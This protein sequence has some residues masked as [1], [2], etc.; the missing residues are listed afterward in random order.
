MGICINI[1]KYEF[2]NG[3]Y[4]YRVVTVDGG[5]HDFFV[6]LSPNEKTIS[7]Y[8]GLDFSNPFRVIY[9]DNPRE[10]IGVDGVSPMISGPV[11]SK[12]AKAIKSNIFPK[13]IGYYA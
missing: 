5:G 2:V 9:I 12:C 7:F 13:S 6:G 1:D 11:I 10:T 4:I 3:V 8:K